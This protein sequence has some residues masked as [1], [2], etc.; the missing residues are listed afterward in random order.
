MKHFKTY[1]YQVNLLWIL[2]CS[3]GSS[4]CTPY[5][6]LTP[7]VLGHHNGYLTKHFIFSTGFKDNRPSFE[8]FIKI[9]VAT[10]PQKTRSGRD[11]SSSSM[12]IWYNTHV[13]WRTTST[14][15]VNGADHLFF[16][17][18]TNTV[19]DHVPFL[20]ATKPVL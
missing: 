19:L 13:F 20:S 4:F 6:S 3:S 17:L 15:Q 16:H 8:Y 2:R 12:L 14:I 7:T 1:T 18:N 11:S 10:S 9:S 5:I